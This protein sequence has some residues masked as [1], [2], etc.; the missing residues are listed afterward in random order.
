MAKFNKP[1]AGST[2]TVNHEGGEAYSF[3]DPRDELLQLVASCL[4]NEPKFYGKTGD[5]EQRITHLCT[6]SAGSDPKF[7]LQLAAYSRNELYLRSVSTYLLAKAAQMVATKPYVRG[8]APNII[9]RADEINEVLAAYL[10]SFGKPLP[11]SLKKGV[12]DSFGNFDEYQ[13]AKYNR[14][15]QVTFRD[16]IMLTHPKKNG[17]LLKKILDKALAVPYTWE[18]ELSAKGNKPEVWHD[19]IDS[20][21]LPYM[22][23]LRNLRNMLKAPIDDA[24]RKKVCEYLANEKA[25]K[26]SRQLPFRF[27]SAFLILSNEGTKGIQDVL[28]ALEDAADIAF[29]NIQKMPGTTMLAIDTSGSM[30]SRLSD[31][32]V[33]CHMDIGLLLGAAAQKFTDDGILS[34]FGANMEVINVSR[35][36]GIISNAMHLRELQGRVGHATN[37]YLTIDWLIKNKRAVDRV[38]I[39]TDCQL[40]D[41]TFSGWGMGYPGT[42]ENTI[43][44]SWHK[45]KKD[46]APN[47]KIYVINLNGYGT[48]AFPDGDTSAVNISGWSEKIFKFI[49]TIEKGSQ[50]N[51]I[52]EH[53]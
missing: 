36:G 42:G 48:T 4:M 38:L 23:M 15:A 41:T 30:G 5:I 6:Q 16:A 8:Y 35:R 33:L 47:A 39:F 32:S 49:E 43:R 3:S 44:K 34:I 2:K 46:V 51:Y 31:R 1:T 13:F 28:D 26:N 52:K 53:Y 19:L 25:V 9:K 14:A 27:Y 24:H 17:E 20:K 50:K 11:N 21:K 18:V 7:I 45:Y 22:A 40:W 10:N 12:A 37:A 29:G